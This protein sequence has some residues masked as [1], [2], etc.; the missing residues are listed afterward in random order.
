MSYNQIQDLPDLVKNHLPIHAAE[1]FRAAFNN[2]EAECGE[3]ECAFRVAW[4]AVKRD[5]EKNFNR[6]LY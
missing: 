1:I 2:A 3:E 6:D 5:N 4:A